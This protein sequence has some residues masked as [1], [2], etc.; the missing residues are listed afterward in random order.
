MTEMSGFRPV[1]SV[2]PAPGTR[3]P[4]TSEPHEPPT[5]VEETSP[6]C[7]ADA[8]DR[9]TTE[10]ERP[11]SGSHARSRGSQFR[12]GVVASRVG[13][14]LGAENGRL[15]SEAARASSTTYE[16]FLATKR[17]SVAASGADATR[18]LPATE[19][20]EPPRMSSA[21]VER[22][23]AVVWKAVAA[24]ISH[25]ELCDALNGTIVETAGAARAWEAVARHDDRAL[26]ALRGELAACPG[27]SEDTVRAALEFLERQV[28]REMGG[29]VELV[30]DPHTGMTRTWWHSAAGERLREPR[31]RDGQGPRPGRAGRGPGC[32]G[33]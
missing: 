4:F 12:P 6:Y 2:P 32:S 14:V 28:D 1:Q 26:A 31:E 16:S 27:V 29:A 23:V 19:V 7:I 3:E 13:N 17:P 18:S 15:G 8:V 5:P 33:R 20:P 11:V 21:T 10:G 25:Q 22:V 30:K 9:L 24:G